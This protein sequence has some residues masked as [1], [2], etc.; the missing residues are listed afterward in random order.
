MS[1]DLDSLVLQSIHLK[2]VEALK[3]TPEM[4]DELVKAATFQEVNQYG[5][6][7]DFHDKK[8][9][10]LT[11]LVQDTIRA[12]ATKVVVEHIASLEPAIKEA[13]RSRISAADM[14]D[15]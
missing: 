2:I 6:K 1:K 12:V 8:M 5:S 14:V 11:W 3:N 4:I 10:Y 15:S 13:V 9:S 7:P